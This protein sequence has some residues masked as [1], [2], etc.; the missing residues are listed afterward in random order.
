[1]R[2]IKLNMERLQVDSYETEPPLARQG[3]T[4]QGHMEGGDPM[5]LND[6]ETIY[7]PCQTAVTCGTMCGLTGSFGGTCYAQCGTDTVVDNPGN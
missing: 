1:M 3:G 7:Y 2:K 5:L 4:I 6:G